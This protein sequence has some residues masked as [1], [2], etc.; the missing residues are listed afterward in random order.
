MPVAEHSL[1]S[2]VNSGA[3]AKFADKRKCFRFQSKSSALARPGTAPYYIIT[4]HFNSYFIFFFFFFFPE[5]PQTSISVGNKESAEL[6]FLRRNR[7]RGLPGQTT[8]KINLC[9]T[10]PKSAMK[11]LVAADIIW[12]LSKFDLIY[13]KLPQYIEHWMSQIV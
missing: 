6:S 5:V 7:L 8:W 11:C 4:V 3:P 1:G 2:T 10:H 13:W 12:Y 9:I